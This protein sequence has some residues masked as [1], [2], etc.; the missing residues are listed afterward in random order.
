M[1]ITVNFRER[2]NSIQEIIEQSKGSLIGDND[3]CPL[4]HFFTEGIYTREIFIPAGTVVV[5]KI[6]KHS[7]PNF[8]VSG[9]VRL[10]TEFDGFEEIVGPKFMISK[11][12]TKRGLYAVT[13]L[14]WVTVHHN[15]SNTQDLGELEK[16]II[17]KDFKEFDA[18]QDKKRGKLVSILNKL[19]KS[20]S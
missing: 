8:L 10:I 14:V 1:N 7:H 18:L 2:I 16:H 6:H 9:T 3:L 15:P 5:G 19:I 13:D 20:L 4:K 12:G 17:A 11:A